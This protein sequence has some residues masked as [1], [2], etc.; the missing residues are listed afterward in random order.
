MGLVEGGRLLR[1]EALRIKAHIESVAPPK[2]ANKKSTGAK[3]E[4]H[5]TPSQ[6][7]QKDLMSSLL[8]F[9]RDHPYSFILEQALDPAEDITLKDL[10]E[11]L[12]KDKNSTVTNT[13]RGLMQFEVM[14]KAV[15]DQAETRLVKLHQDMLDELDKCKAAY[16]E[17]SAK[18]ICNGLTAL[19]LNGREAVLRKCPLVTSEVGERELRLSKSRASQALILQRA[20]AHQLDLEH[21]D[22][23][24]PSLPLAQ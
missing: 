1:S 9:L 18:H 5:L 7:H 2:K 3:A 6:K 19:S 10:K 8:G 4:T 16:V 13:D 11:V 12:D 14:I 23:G 20:I 17:D 24:V 22:K 15:F 21:G